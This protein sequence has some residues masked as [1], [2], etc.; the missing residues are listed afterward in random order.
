VYLKD[1]DYLLGLEGG[2]REEAAL[3]SINKIKT[4]EVAVEAP[5]EERRS[6][7]LELAIKVEGQQE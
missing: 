2:I 4:Q 7:I 6:A 5:Q 3:T 1:G